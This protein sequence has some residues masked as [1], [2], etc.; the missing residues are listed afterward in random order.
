MQAKGGLRWV[1]EGRIAR[2]VLPVMSMVLWVW[3]VTL[4]ERGH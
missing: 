1:A 3:L 2:R 4:I